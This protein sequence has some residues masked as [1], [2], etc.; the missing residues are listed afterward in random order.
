MKID[1]VEL[2]LFNWDNIPPTRYHAGS[3]NLG[4]S[5]NL[6][7]LTIKTD[8]GI[9]G[10]AFL[11]GATNPAESDAGA[12]IRFLKP[13]LM[14][15]DP[16]ARVELHAALR[17]RQRTAGLRTVGACDT[18]LWDIAAKA[19]NLPLYKFLGAGRASIGA[20]A[21]SQILDGRQ[22]YAGEAAEFKSNGWK[23]YKIHP[24]QDPAEDIKVCEAVRKSV[25]DD[26]T[27]MLDSTW[28]YKYPEA[29]KVGRAV[30]EM[31]Y[32][33]FEDPLNEEDIYSYVKLR[34]KLNIPILATEYPPGD[35][36]TYAVWLTERA[37]DYL[38]GDIPVKGGISTLIKTAHLAEAFH[39]N[40][41]VHH[42][43][44]SHNNMAQLHFACSLKNTTFF[45]VLLP[46]GAHKY[47]VLNDIKIDKNGMAHCPETPGIGA[48]I[49]F[50]LIKK[51]QVAVLK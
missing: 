37:T 9:T 22:A 47:G 29:L 45:E 33:W 8:A 48:E 13:L 49:D 21:S 42:G 23:A 51:K 20:Y 30:E 7:L 25:G 27:L 14:G 28:S 26:Y 38:R 41:E 18:A 2:T 39:M 11:G 36:G 17:A 3:R 5:S 15:Q 4:G 43:G 1:D 19:A 31:G 34:Q 24:P 40:Y 16:L 6:G 46:D 50:D 44:N 32:L 12:L 35:I 10:H